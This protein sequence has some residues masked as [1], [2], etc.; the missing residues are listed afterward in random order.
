MDIEPDEAHFMHTL[1]IFKSPRQG[2]STLSQASNNLSHLGFVVLA[3]PQAL[4]LRNFGLTAF[5]RHARHAW[6]V[7][8]GDGYPGALQC[9]P[10]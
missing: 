3:R 4:R 9:V 6:I 10:G 2:I 7:L 5:E 8:A 1:H